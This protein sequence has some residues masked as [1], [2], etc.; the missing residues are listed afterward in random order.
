VLTAPANTPQYQRVCIC[1]Y[2]HSYIH[3][4]ACIYIHTCMYIHTYMHAYVGYMYVHPY[5]QTLELREVCYGLHRVERESAKAL[6]SLKSLK[7]EAEQKGP[8]R[9]QRFCRRRL[10]QLQTASP[11]GLRS[12]KQQQQAFSTHVERE[13]SETRLCLSIRIHDERSMVHVIIVDPRPVV[14]S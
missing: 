13:C 3:V 7:S 2:I 6:K 5:T 14:H 12:T 10:L 9:R 1:I 11:C 8:L 4:Y